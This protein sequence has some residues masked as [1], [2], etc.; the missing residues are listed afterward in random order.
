[1]PHIFTLPH[2]QQRLEPSPLEPLSFGGQ[3]ENSKAQQEFINT[4]VSRPWQWLVVGAIKRREGGYRLSAWLADGMG[5]ECMLL[6]Y[7]VSTLDVAKALLEAS[8]RA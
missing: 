7:E 2:K 1:L 5:G 8:E 6:C 3:H 4:A